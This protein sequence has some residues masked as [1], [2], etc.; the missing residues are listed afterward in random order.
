MYRFRNHQVYLIPKPKLKDKPVG[1]S[2]LDVALYEAG[3]LKFGE[4]YFFIHPNLVLD[5]YINTDIEPILEFLDE[6]GVNLKKEAYLKEDTGTICFQFDTDEDYHLAKLSGFFDIWHYANPGAVTAD[7]IT[8]LQKIYGLG[9]YDPG[10]FK[11]V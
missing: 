10:A 6:K 7:V 2:W 1:T 3:I 8:K 9:Y 4:K 5:V 11:T